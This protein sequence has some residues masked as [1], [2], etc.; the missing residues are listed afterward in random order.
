MTLSSG[1]GLLLGF[2]L[3]GVL[4]PLVWLR[5]Q[6]PAVRGA[7]E[8]QDRF[9]VQR[10]S[11]LR[12]RLMDGMGA[13][14]VGQPAL[15]VLRERLLSEFQQLGLPLEVQSTF[16]CS[17]YGTCATVANLLGR[18]PG[19]GPR[20]AG[21]HAVMLAVHYDSVGAGPGVSDDFNGT[22]AMLEIARLL[23]AGPAPRNDIILLITDGEEY[24]LLG[25]HAFA[26]HPW[27]SEVAAVVN[28]EARGTSGLSY[29]FETGV[30]N[31]WLVD[32]YAE[33]V[34]RP[35]TNS[36]AY[37]VYK[38]MPN[39]TDLTVFKAHGMN[40]L[41]VANI[42][43]V[44]HY[45]TPYD[46][47]VHSDPRTLQHHGDVALSLIRALGEVDL[48]VEHL[49]DAAF[50]DL[51]GLCVL[52]W[53][54]GWTPVIALVG[55]LLVFA[56]AWRWSRQEPLTL[57]QL[58]WASLGWWGLVLLCA[59][60]GFAFFK[61]LEFTGAASAPWIAHPGPA[62]AAFGLFLVWVFLLLCRLIAGRASGTARWTAVWSWWGLL[63]VG[64]SLAF[65]DAIPAL[66]LPVPV[67]GLVAVLSPRGGSRAVAVGVGTLAACLLLLPLIFFMESTLGLPALT[68][69]GLVAGLMLA[70]L[71]PLAPARLPRGG[72]LIGVCAVGVV[73]LSL[74]A[75]FLSPYSDQAP[76]RLNIVYRFDSDRQR[77]FWAL[78]GDLSRVPEPLAEFRQSMRE[79]T[80]PWA[81]TP[82]PL[83]LSTASAGLTAPELE[84]TRIETVAGG[85]ILHLKVRSTRG[86]PIVN[87]A[88]SPG[89][90]ITSVRVNGQPQPAQKE[91]IRKLYSPWRPISCVTD[92]PD[93][94]S[95][96]VVLEGSEPIEAF[97]SDES[98]GVPPGKFSRRAEWKDF[99]PSQNGDVTLTLRS[100]KL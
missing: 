95:V 76:Q 28:V 44:V 77:D 9:S 16:V 41:G 96:E 67:V 27:A 63:M 71:L 14:R 20:A 99:V 78:E 4:L 19:R 50:V 12:A 1:R 48:S 62:F 26:K 5:G 97:L 43:G 51:M 91:R 80:T 73:G 55:L 40:G 64:L 82:S 30:N 60:V 38:K 86:A 69:V 66:L 11:A 87:V 54:V 47:L 56:G 49:G 3:L 98:P 90:R 75:S 61:L 21:R 24:G 7:E 15:R 18:I 8:S 57:R 37:A 81:K 39:D 32:L 13:H 93:G 65:P 25:A 84:P 22:A 79:K 72:M 42:D 68:L 58:G 89:E 10:A 6:P 94:C 35:A 29:L 53:P 33:H 17:D 34:D 83:L 92:S 45:H 59:G 46:D 88:F 74:W 70:T 85:R 2:L 52:H 23:K 36:L 31:A 100:L